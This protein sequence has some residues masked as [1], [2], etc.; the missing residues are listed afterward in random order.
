MVSVIFLPA[1]LASARNSK[2]RDSQ[3]QKG[4]LMSYQRKTKD[5]WDIMT[6]WGY[7]WECENSEYTRADAKRSLK[8]YRENLA[9]RAD[10]RMEKHREPITA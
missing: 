2:R 8:E 7:G 9:G 4:V 6:N 1:I 10:V 3:T 5:R